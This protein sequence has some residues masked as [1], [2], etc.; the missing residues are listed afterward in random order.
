[1]GRKDLD[2]L[3]LIVA[4]LFGALIISEIFRMLIKRIVSI[5]A[6]KM[7]IDPTNYSFIKNAA[8]FTIY[9][10]AISFVVYSVPRFKAI[11][12]TLFAGAGIFAAII[13]L[14]S[15]QAFSNIISGI[16]IVLSKP[17]RVGDYIELNQIHKGTVEDITLRHTIMRDIQNNR[18]IVPNSQI[19]T[20]TIIN[21]HLNDERKREKVEFV[22][23]IESDMDLAMAIMK[24]EIAHHTGYLKF[25]LEPEPEELKVRVM[26][27]E[28]GTVTLR[29]MVG[30]PNPDTAYEMHCDLNHIIKKRFDEEG[31]KF[32]KR[33]GYIN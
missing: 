6:Q 17:F 28:N 12:G 1:M 13:A 4:T 30:S 14:A 27:I 29:S 15:Q 22:I 21:Y 3:I 23:D 18:I 25:K 11:G 19:N 10:I 2:Y 20:E 16:F 32:A 33:V 8:S 7:K 26:K 31:I 5:N 9:T 24:E